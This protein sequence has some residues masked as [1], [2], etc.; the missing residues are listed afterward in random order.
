MNV[1]DN[2]D[3]W[4]AYEQ[5]QEALLDKLPE[6]ER[7]GKL[8]QDDYYFEIDNEIICE[9]CLNSRYRKNTEDFAK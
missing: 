9:D 3:L 4:L 6:C 2:Y 1:P 8:I 5:A 7:C